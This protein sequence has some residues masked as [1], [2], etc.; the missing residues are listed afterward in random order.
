MQKNRAIASLGHR[1]LLMPVWVKAALAANDRLKVYLTVLQACSAHADHPDRE[2]LDLANEL[3]AAGLD[4]ATWLH[5]LPAS[6]S[7]VDGV[8]L[9]PELPTLI[10]ALAEDL[11]L[12]ARPVLEASTTDAEPHARVQHWQAWLAERQEISSTRCSCTT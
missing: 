6:A 8:L 10:H 2:A 1:G 7:R 4:H 5:E 9:V 12:M 11:T 3:Q